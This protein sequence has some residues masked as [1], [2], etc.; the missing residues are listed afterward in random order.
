MAAASSAIPAP[1]AS[2]L[3]MVWLKLKLPLSAELDQYSSVQREDFPVFLA[4]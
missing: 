1:A 4:F 3:R 2:C